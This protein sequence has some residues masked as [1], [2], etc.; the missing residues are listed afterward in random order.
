ML[1][2]LRL[3]AAGV[4]GCG[5]G[6]SSSPRVVTVD[7]ATRSSCGRSTTAYDLSCVSSLEVRVVNASGE[8]QS[9]RCLAVSD[10]YRDLSDLISPSA[11]QDLLAGIAA[12]PQVRI[13]VRGYLGVDVLPCT[14]LSDSALMFWGSSDLVNLNDAGVGAVLVQMECRPDCDCTAINSPSSGCPVDFT[15]GVC[16]PPSQVLCRQACTDDHACYAGLLTCQSNSCTAPAGGLCADC[17]ATSACDSSVSSSVCVQNSTTGEDFCARRCPQPEGAAPCPEL[18]SCK[19]VVG[20]FS[21][22]P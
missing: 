20:A 15:P 5:T 21:V 12:S 9:E 4:A 18:M 2:M 3:I 17:T 19:R 1:R 14:S 7:L 16:A 11:T 22:L 6:C 10:R 8:I 13:E